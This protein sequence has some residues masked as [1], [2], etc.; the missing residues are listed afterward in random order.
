MQH[1]LALIDPTHSSRVSC[2]EEEEG[3]AEEKDVHH[4]EWAKFLDRTHQLQEVLPAYFTFLAIAGD[5]VSREVVPT[6]SRQAGE[7][8]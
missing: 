2:G 6:S 5:R 1:T 4:Q 3:E 7:E 8:S